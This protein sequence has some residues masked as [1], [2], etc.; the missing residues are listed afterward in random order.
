VP[1]TL[2]VAITPEPGGDE[3]QE[4][5]CFRGLSV[6]GLLAGDLDSGTS[7]WSEQACGLRLPVAAETPPSL[8]W[9]QL[10]APPA[11]APIE[12]RLLAGDQLPVLLLSGP[13]DASCPV[14][15]PE[16]ADVPDTACVGEPGEPVAP[17]IAT[18]CDVC[19]V[20]GRSFEEQP[21]P[22]V[23]YRQWRAGP[24]EPASDFAQ[25]S[26]LVDPFCNA[27]LLSQLDDPFVSVVRFGAGDPW[28]GQRLLFVDRTPY[29]ED[30]E[31]RYQV[32]FFS[33]DGEVR[34][35]R[36]SPWIAL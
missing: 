4:E 17:F 24:A 16:C 11:G 35:S 13:I 34:A 28:S 27:G 6:G 33:S 15:L 5:W 30:V 19:E 14:F 12:A 25:V 23:V 3:W 9:P 36:T 31:V 8:G 18:A 10:P 2:E 21:P 1:Q 29:R 22:F 20:I 32:V 26:P 7:D